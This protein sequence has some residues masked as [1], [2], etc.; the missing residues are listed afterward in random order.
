MGQTATFGIFVTGTS[1]VPFDPANNRIF[2]RFNDAGGVT[3]GA[4]SASVAARAEQAT[5]AGPSQGL[6]RSA[7]RWFSL[8]LLRSPGLVALRVHITLWHAIAPDARQ[9]GFP[10]NHA[11]MWASSARRRSWSRLP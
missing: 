7:G 8:A 9:D 11:T 1:T 10:A 6:L 5:L 2:V 4:T 3:R